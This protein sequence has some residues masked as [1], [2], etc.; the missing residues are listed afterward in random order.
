MSVSGVWGEK[1][2]QKRNVEMNIEHEHGGGVG[3]GFDLELYELLAVACVDFLVVGGSQLRL[4]APHAAL[5]SAHCAS[6]PVLLHTHAPLGHS[7]CRYW[8]RFD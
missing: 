4:V 6:A 1:K 8:L 7:L 2:T 3:C 5:V